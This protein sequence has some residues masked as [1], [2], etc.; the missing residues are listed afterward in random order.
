MAPKEGF[1]LSPLIVFLILGFAP[2]LPA[3]GAFESG[4]AVVASVNGV[5]IPESFL[6]R[7]VQRF[8]QEALNQGQLPEETDKGQIHGEA[9]DTLISM[10]LLFQESQK[11]G[12]TVEEA[13]VDEQLQTIK[14]RFPD[15]ARFNSALEEMS[16][17]EKELKEEIRRKLGIQ[18]LVSR[19]LSPAIEVS[20]EEAKGYYEANAK[21][22]TQPERVRASH[23]L[24]AVSEGASEV[25]KA[26]AREKLQEIRRRVQ[27]GED[28]AQLAR[29]FSQDS[30]GVQGGDL[31]YF[32]R[33]ETAPP[34][35]QA[36]FD[37]P[38]GE[39]SEIVAS[40]NGYHLIQVTD[41]KPQ[42]LLAF[43]EVQERLT[44]FLKRNKL[45]DRME[46]LAAELKTK[47]DIQKFP[48]KTG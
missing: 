15:A 4:Q 10:E 41:R 48:P 20:D 24:I 19:D 18:E 33:G 26:A 45:M 1:R 9:L 6:K 37:L 2:C 16:Y 25:E 42:S 23:I 17:T 40:E 14:G 43:G 28:F 7:E 32:N 8:E 3:A 13:R 22:F 36:A 34:F 38:V 27:G 5:G 21:L 31:G 11:R 39:V 35:G 29:E 30:T 12:Y 46:Q 47:A 44:Q